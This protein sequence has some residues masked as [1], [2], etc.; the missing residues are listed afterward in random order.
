MFK[1]LCSLCLTA[2]ALT[3]LAA[4]EVRA[5]AFFS[6][7]MGYDFGGDS[8]CQTLRGCEEKKLNAGIAFG[9]LGAASGFEQ[10]F[11]Y[12]KNFF[13][14]VDGQE[15]SVLTL[16][17]NF[18]IAPKIGPVRPYGLFGLGLMKTNVDLTFGDVASFSNNHFAWDIGGGLMVFFGEHF[19]IR[20]DIRHFHSFQSLNIQGFALNNTK[21]DFGRASL[22]I[23]LK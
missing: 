17:S 22:A 13:G 2:A 19:G 7:F 4:T 1:K 15:S 21:L 18:M 5:Q 14:S 16:M 23:V 11:A 9:S 20:G 3:M 6:P 10:E 12:A 8:G